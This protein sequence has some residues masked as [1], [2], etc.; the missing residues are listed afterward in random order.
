MFSKV[1][2]YKAQKRMGCPVMANPFIFLSFFGGAE[3]GI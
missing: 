2:E 1:K 3:G